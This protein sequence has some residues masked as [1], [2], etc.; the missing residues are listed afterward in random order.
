MPQPFKVLHYA[1]LI[2]PLLIFIA[3]VM[4]ISFGLDAVIG[5]FCA[6]LEDLCGRAEM[7]DD[8]REESEW[9]PLSLADIKVLV[10]DV[11]SIR[12]KNY[13]HLVP[14]DILVRTLRVLDHQI[15][16]A[17]GLS[18]NECEH[19]SLRF[20]IHMLFVVDMYCTQQLRHAN[21]VV[22]LLL[23]KLYMCICTEW[24]YLQR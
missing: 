15:H 14:V 9:L 19:V 5:G 8:D 18:I 2:T 1:F 16:R 23:Y 13:L 3:E 20:S 6:G 22:A 12:A 4:L 21:W 10:N 24:Q 17:E 11:V 7:N